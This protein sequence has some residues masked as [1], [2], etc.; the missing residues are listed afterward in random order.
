MNVDQRGDI[1]DLFARQKEIKRGEI[2]KHFLN[3]NPEFGR[4]AKSI[5]Y[6]LDEKIESLEQALN[7]ILLKDRKSFATN[8]Y[9]IQ[10][11]EKS[12]A[13]SGE[14]EEDVETFLILLEE[15]YES[16]QYWLENH[17]QIIKQDGSAEIIRLDFLNKSTTLV[18]ESE[19]SEEL[20]KRLKELFEMAKRQN[21]YPSTQELR[22]LFDELGLDQEGVMY[23]ELLKLALENEQKDA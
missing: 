21:R 14:S 3:S 10:S 19:N 18:D 17:N 23:Q 5:L 9:N 4:L 1:I 11:Q 2:I 12:M 13:R 15:L 6:I 8:I 22:S 7:R 16:Y 20:L